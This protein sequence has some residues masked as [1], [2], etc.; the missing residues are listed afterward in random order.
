MILLSKRFL[1]IGVFICLLMGSL[2]IL[3]SLIQLIDR[4][5]FLEKITSF[6]PMLSQGSFSK[7]ITKSWI[8]YSTI[9]FLVG[10]ALV[11]TGTCFFLTMRRS[12]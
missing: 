1:I 8:R 6:N 2:L 12:K 11:L 9:E 4:D 7:E 5:Y 3:F 10:V